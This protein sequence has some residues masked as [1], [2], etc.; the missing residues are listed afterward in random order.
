VQQTLAEGVTILI[1][2]L[3]KEVTHLTVR[4]FGSGCGNE[5]NRLL[6]EAT[7]YRL[8]ADSMPNTKFDLQVQTDLLFAAQTLWDK[9]SGL[10]CIL[11]TGANAGYYADGKVAQAPSLGFWLG[12]EGSGGW[13]GKEI[14]KA[15]YRD[16]LPER[17][18]ASLSEVIVPRDQ[19]LSN[20]YKHSRPSEVAARLVTL[21]QDEEL[22]PFLKIGLQQ[23]IELYILPLAIKYNSNQIRAVGGIAWRFQ[24]ELRASLASY[25]LHLVEAVNRPLEVWL[26]NKPIV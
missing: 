22:S 18:L 21:A 13:L 5:P 10:V 1:D 20:F 16:E 4:Y 24:Q 14:I 23:Y 11:G 6:I 17:L 12:D 26:G 15:Y 19:F 25:D 8:L 9:E 7:L 2:L 3:P